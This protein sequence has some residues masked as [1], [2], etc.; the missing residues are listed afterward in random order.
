MKR[1]TTNECLKTTAAAIR[2]EAQKI[3]GA[4]KGNYL[5]LA[6]LV[7]EDK[8]SEVNKLLY[9]LQNQRDRNIDKYSPQPMPYNSPIVNK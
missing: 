1:L 2:L 4:D 6:Y 5:T 7:E 9:E 3:I 8:L